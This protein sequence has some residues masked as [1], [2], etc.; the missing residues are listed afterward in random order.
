MADISRIELDGNV[1]DLKDNTARKA[2]IG[3][4]YGNYNAGKSYKFGDFCLYDNNLYKCIKDTTGAWDAGSWEETSPLE[5][6][7]SLRKSLDALDT[8]MGGATKSKAGTAGLVPAPAAGEQGKYLKGD[9]TW[10]TPPDTVYEHPTTAGNNHIPAGGAV[11]KF[12]KWLSDGVAQWASLGAAAM[13]NVSN[14]DTTTEEGFLADARRIK[15]LR[16]DVEALNSALDGKIPFASTDKT[17]EVD[18]PTLLFGQKFTPYGILYTN[19]GVKL[20]LG[21]TYPNGLYGAQLMFNFDGRIMWRTINIA[22][23]KG[24]TDWVSIR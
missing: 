5:E 10:G 11:G 23:G 12:L 15:A 4:A 17:A 24:W 3:G 13:Y 8:L 6:I 22:D 21:Y 14:N 9:G 1:Y 19:N 18:N 2:I 16:D 20:I 7:E